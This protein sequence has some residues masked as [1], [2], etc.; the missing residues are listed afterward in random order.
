VLVKSKLRKKGFEETSRVCAVV[1]KNC[2]YIS[3]VHMEQQSAV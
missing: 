3:H 1:E 2:K